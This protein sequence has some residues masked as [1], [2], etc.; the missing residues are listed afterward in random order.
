MYNLHKYQHRDNKTFKSY[1]KVFKQ[2][3]KLNSVLNKTNKKLIHKNQIIK[4]FKRIYNN[5]SKNTY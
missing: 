1:Y 4:K 2:E 5:Q 3:N